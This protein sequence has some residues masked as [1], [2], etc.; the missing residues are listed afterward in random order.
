[1]F[2]EAFAK[3]HLSINMWPPSPEQRS[4]RENSSL[5]LTAP[6]MMLLII[7][8]KIEIRIKMFRQ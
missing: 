7:K 6:E 5:S 1:M 3:S 8:Q 4:S 2:K